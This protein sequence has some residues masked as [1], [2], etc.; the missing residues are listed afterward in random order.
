MCNYREGDS[1]ETSYALYKWLAQRAAE[2]GRP[3][4]DAEVL[5]ALA[6][7]L[8]AG[9][10]T[11]AERRRWFRGWADDSCQCGYADCEHHP[12]SSCDNRQP[13]FPFI[14]IEPALQDKP[15]VQWLCPPCYERR[16]EHLEIAT[17][18][19]LARA[20]RGREGG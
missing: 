18:V 9:S 4:T 10:E 19:A 16:V 6:L 11:G 13:L 12:S 14:E 20:A 1:L 3:L 2:Q 15:F 5:A 7:A 17:V 8:P